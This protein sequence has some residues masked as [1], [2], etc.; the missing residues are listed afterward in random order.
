METYL[1]LAE[2]K[3]ALHVGKGR[4]VV[5]AMHHGIEDRLDLV[6]DACI[7]SQAYDP[8]CEDSREK[9]LMSMISRSPSYPVIRAAI[10]DELASTTDSRDVSQ[11]F[12][13]TKEMALAG[14][15]DA[16]QLLEKRTC[17]IA[18]TDCCDGWFGVDEWIELDGEEAVLELARIY[19]KRL[20]TN[21]DALVCDTMFTC[22]PARQS[23]KQVLLQATEDDTA[24]SA[25]RDYLVARGCF[26]SRSPRL[27]PEEAKAERRQRLRAQYKL[28]QILED[29]A[30]GV[31][32]LPSRYMTFGRNATPDELNQILDRLLS[33]QRESSLVRLLW[34]FRRTPLPRLH[35][36]IFDW[37][38]APTFELR[39]AAIAALSRNQDPQ[40]HQLAIQKAASRALIGADCEALELFLNN[41]WAGDSDA[42]I[43]ALRSIAPTEDDAHRLG[44]SVLELA[45]KHQDPALGGALLWTYENTPCSTCRGSAVEQLDR[46]GQL[47]ESLAAECRF[48]ADERARKVA[49]N[50]LKEHS[51]G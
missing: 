10:L 21:P 22:E 27:S 26:D 1:N 48:D 51:A 14:D 45:E 16:R 4:A 30:N 24:L 29:A 12:G 42:I 31:G 35:P 7:H 34:I 49:V 23:Y 46:V 44:L 28:E 15:K 40:V 47:T 9:W 19:G 5:H 20:L 36:K 13:L 18:Q 41:Y 3:R 38:N 50:W 37:T 17:E 32:R 25:Y 39:A 43:D 8:Q 6:R 33:E 2:F 11:L